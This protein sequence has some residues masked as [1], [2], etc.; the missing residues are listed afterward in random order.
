MR[1]V[2]ISPANNFTAEFHGPYL[3]FWVK[4]VENVL[5]PME[6]KLCYPRG[7]KDIA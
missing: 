4:H 7:K 3:P 2:I 6:N 5:G 1:I